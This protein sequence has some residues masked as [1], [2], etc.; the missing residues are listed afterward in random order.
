MGDSIICYDDD[1]V[2]AALNGFW[3]DRSAASS[4][5]ECGGAT[6]DAS[7][8]SA[9]GPTSEAVVL[10]DYELEALIAMGS[11]S[12]SKQPKRSRTEQALVGTLAALKKKGGVNET[13]KAI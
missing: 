9:G 10:V 2:L 3:P 1:D 7:S 13:P 6:A 5:Q 11:S 12:N 8:T 4:L